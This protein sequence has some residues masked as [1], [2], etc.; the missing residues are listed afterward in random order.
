MCVERTI[1]FVN[2]FYPKSK[3]ED[4]KRIFYSL[5]S[6]WFLKFTLITHPAGRHFDFFSDNS[7]SSENRVCFGFKGCYGDKVHGL[8][9]GRGGLGKNIFTFALLD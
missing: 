2:K 6:K 8:G 4:Q 9:Y 1:S 3:G 5:F 7:L